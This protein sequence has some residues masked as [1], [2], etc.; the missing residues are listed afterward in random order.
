MKHSVVQIHKHIAAFSARNLPDSADLA[1]A[2]VALIL[3]E[4]PEFSDVELL[5]IRRSEHPRDPWSGHMGFPGGRVESSD[6]SPLQTAKRETKEEVGI[7]LD[8]SARFL[9]RL[10]ELRAR[11]RRKLLKM[12][13]FPFVFATTEQFE[14]QRN[15][16]V[17]EAVWIPLEFFLD[18]RN[19][20]ELQVSTEGNEYSFPCYIY[21]GR[22][23]W[24]LSLMMLDEFLFE[25]LPAGSCI[26]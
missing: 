18:R 22:T 7:N 15:E 21:D 5:L 25:A 6:E 13:I 1:H 20:E 26:S 23:I 12:S 17:S 11:S 19:R 24:G 10:S 9:G 16:E 3:R 14:L 8:T 2:A 4:R